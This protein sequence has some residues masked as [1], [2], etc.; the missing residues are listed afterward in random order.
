MELD[1]RH[2]TTQRVTLIGAAVN[3]GLA[4]LQ[5]VFGVL[6]KSQAL[7]A[8]GIHT[9]SD[10]VT[11]FIVLY[12]SR[13][14]SREA[15]KAHPYGHGRIETLASMLLGVILGMV[16]IGI[17]IRGVES[18]LEPPQSGPEV[19]TVFFAFIAIV[20]KEGLYRYT[21]N[22]ARATHSAMLESN[23][24]HHRSDALSSIVVL[25]GISAQLLG[26]AY[27]DAVA[28]IIVACMISWMGLRLTRNALSELIDTGL[29][30][31]L[32][33]Q[34]RTAMM[35]NPSV[36]GVHNLRSR[37]MGGL[38]YIDAHIEVDPDL[39][40]SE[41]HY[42]AH[43]IEHH[44]KKRFPKIIDVQIHIDPIDDKIR[45]SV[46]ARLPDR[47][48][49]EQDLAQAW[50]G[51]DASASIQQTKL[52]YLDTLIEIDL[53]LPA[54]MCSLE[55]QADIENLRQGASSL[56]YIGKVNIYYLVV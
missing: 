28:A 29:D 25:V 13:R 14:S 20:A 1:Q 37:S 12:A 56:D 36:V 51:S 23:A 6:G 21:L 2:R 30:L 49:I 35:A 11:D 47:Q 19:I 24:W 41:A 9:L 44:V 16:G 17:G 55:H 26:I 45:D 40:V 38:G 15:D 31:D 48:R 33:E 34:V 10:L 52:H 50:G 43:R 5:I 4:S 22:A 27:M 8:D 53:V 32:V 39:T 54:S 42:I 7:L 18:I 3:C 46:L